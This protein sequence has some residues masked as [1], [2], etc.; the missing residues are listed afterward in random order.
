M[1]LTEF[2]DRIKLE[3][4]I[5]FETKDIEQSIIRKARK[6]KTGNCAAVDDETVKQW[7]LEYDPEKEKPPVIDESKKVRVV[8]GTGTVAVPVGKP[9]EKENEWGTQQSLF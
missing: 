6:V 4:N 7:I 1:T 8:P 5:Q 3:N 9:E 2:I